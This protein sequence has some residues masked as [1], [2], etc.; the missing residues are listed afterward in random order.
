MSSAKPRNQKFMIN[1][2]Y[3]SKNFTFSLSTLNSVTVG[4]AVSNFKIGE[5][6][7]LKMFIALNCSKKPYSGLP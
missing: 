3:A 4:E 7:A 1:F 2:I 5:T 6:Q